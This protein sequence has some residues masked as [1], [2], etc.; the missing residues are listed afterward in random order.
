M[1]NQIK[2][3]A[4]GAKPSQYQSALSSQPLSNRLQSQSNED[5]QATNLVPSKNQL[6]INQGQ[7]TERRMK[8]DAFYSQSH[9]QCYG[10]GINSLE[11]RIGDKQTPLKKMQA[12]KS[13]EQNFEAP[14]SSENYIQL[15]NRNT[16]VP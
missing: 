9:F 10:G 8:S 16:A 12:T 13:A 11:S 14:N 4:T 2:F 7:K 1:R 6:P 5:F 3:V 15:N